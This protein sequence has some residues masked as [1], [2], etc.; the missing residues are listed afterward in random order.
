MHPD[1]G[2]ITSLREISVG[3]FSLVGVYPFVWA[4]VFIVIETEFAF[5]ARLNIAQSM[6]A[7]LGEQ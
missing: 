7:E 2:G 3:V 5:H 1:V 4:V 6:S